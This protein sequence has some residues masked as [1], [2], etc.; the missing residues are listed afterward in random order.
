[1]PTSNA[2]F[3]D[4]VTRSFR[5]TADA[6]Y[7]AAR[8]LYRILLDQQFLWAALQAIEKY[9][10]AILLYHR[11]STKRL[12]HDICRALHQIRAIDAIAFDVS[13]DVEKFIQQLAVYG[14]NRYFEHL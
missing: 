6:D 2:K 8:A 1:M 14:C 9:L 12:G 4:Y 11:V 13:S 5:D 10:K 3:N 7:V